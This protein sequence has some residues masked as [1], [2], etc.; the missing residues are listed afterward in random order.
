[1][2]SGLHVN[3]GLYS[4]LTS[5]RFYK[6][7]PHLRVY[8]MVYWQITLGNRESSRSTSV[9]ANFSQYNQNDGSLQKRKQSYC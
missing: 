5:Q 4:H 1:M 9:H 2:R 7:K 3:S 6:E 8:T